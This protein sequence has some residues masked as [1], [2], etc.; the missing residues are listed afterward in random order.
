[1]ALTLNIQ[2]IVQDFSRNNLFEVEIPYLGPNFKFICKAS[3]LPGSKVG[4]VKVQYQNREISLPGDR[5]YDD[6]KVTVYNTADQS[7]RGQFL[8]WMNLIQRSGKELGG[9]LPAEIKS[10][11]FVRQFD[12][13]GNKTVEFKMS[14]IFPID[15]S[16]IGLAWAS[17]GEVGTFEV[18]FAIDWWERIS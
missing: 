10:T 8:E 12:R 7:S 5:T 16:E 6:W 9:A 17:G 1:M 3:A 18:S 13:A 2:D 4:A 15:V 11:G 14:G